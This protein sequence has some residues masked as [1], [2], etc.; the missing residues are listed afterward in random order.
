MSET[1]NKLEEFLNTQMRMSHIY[2]PIMLM[3]LLGSGGHASVIDIAK[4]F[5]MRDP[6]QIQYYAE[7]TRRMPGRVLTQNRH[8]TQKIDDGY[9]LIGFET[10]SR[11]EVDRLIELCDA[12]VEAFLAARIQDPWAHRR[13]SSRVISG[14]ARYE[15]LTRAKGLCELCGI[16]KNVRALEVDH[17]DPRSKGGAN[18][19]SN[20]QAL[21]YRCN[22]NKGNRDNTDFRS[23]S[24]GYENRVS[25][26]RLC[27]PNDR[28][29]VADDRLAYAMPDD[30]PITEDHTV[31]APKRH[32][33]NYFDLHQPEL[34]AIRRILQERKT[35]IELS[36]ETVTGFNVGFDVSESAGQ[37]LSHCFLQLIP[38]RGGDGASGNGNGLRNVIPC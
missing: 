11:A 16:S 32:I 31:I 33:G 26:C 8:I 12:K 15:V 14:S 17:I 30:S 35:A 21:C 19:I 24:N 3:E 9:R 36:D 38:R 28:V 22:S 37:V 20:L 7:I 23:V 34:N 18:D 27:A 1:C 4:A 25:D 6:S 10:L 29:V 2:Q 5:L 13:L